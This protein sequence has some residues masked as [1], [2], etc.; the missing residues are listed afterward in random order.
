MYI[1]QNHPKGT[2]SD[3]DWAGGTVERPVYW[4]V[5]STRM[6]QGRVQQGSQDMCRVILVLAANLNMSFSFLFLVLKCL[7]SYHHIIVVNNGRTSAVDDGFE[8]QKDFLGGGGKFR[9]QGEC[10]F[11]LL[12]SFGVGLFVWSK[13]KLSIAMVASETSQGANLWK[14]FG[15]WYFL[16][17]DISCISYKYCRLS[18]CLYLLAMLFFYPHLPQYIWNT[19]S[20]QKPR[21]KEN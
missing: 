12:L 19:T 15:D 2:E 13:I 4:H 8:R 18:V 1:Y 11:H 3:C 9:K 17:L 21:N 7:S 20:K 5:L 14:S 10:R 16:F 6:L